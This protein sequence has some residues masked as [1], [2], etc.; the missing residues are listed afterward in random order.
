MQQWTTRQEMMESW[1]RELRHADYSVAEHLTT[2]TLTSE[3]L[4]KLRDK[5]DRHLLEPGIQ[6]L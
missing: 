2:L 4:L 5:E 6:G 1:E 3:W